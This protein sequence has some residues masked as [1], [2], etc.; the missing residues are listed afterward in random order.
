[1]PETAWCGVWTVKAGWLFP[2]GTGTRWKTFG[3][4]L[5]PRQ[6]LSAHQRSLDFSDCMALEL[7]RAEGHLPFAIFDKATAKLRDAV[8]P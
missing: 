4:P 2:A 5:P 8:I 7:A 6:K 1:M 3:Q